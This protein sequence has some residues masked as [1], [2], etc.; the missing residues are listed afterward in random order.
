[1][2]LLS[3]GHSIAIARGIIS[4]SFTS[5]FLPVLILTCNF[6]KLILFVC[7]R[8]FTFA[9]WSNAT[10]KKISTASKC[11]SSNSHKDSRICHL[12]LKWICALLAP[13]VICEPI[14]L[15][16]FRNWLFACFIDICFQ[17]FSML[18]LWV[19]HLFLLGLSLSYKW[20][21]VLVSAVGSRTS[22]FPSWPQL[23]QRKPKRMS[24]DW[25]VEL[26]SAIH[27]CDWAKEII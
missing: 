8:N 2:F 24:G 26:D 21:E 23:L 20:I 5:L 13:L 19:L 27:I 1:M 10:R 16:A 15:F 14:L 12:R 17:P 18:F 25:A 6:A 9:K 3:V 22:Q 11:V 7:A 4:L